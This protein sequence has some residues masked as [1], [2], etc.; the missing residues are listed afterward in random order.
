M[1]PKSSPL[2]LSFYWNFASRPKRKSS[3]KK[4][5]CYITNF[6]QRLKK[7]SLKS[8]SV[9]VFQRALFKDPKKRS[10]KTLTLTD[11]K[12][13]FF[14]S[15]KSAPKSALWKLLHLQ[16]SKSA[17]QRPKKALFEICKCKSFSK[18]AFLGL[19]KRSLK[20]L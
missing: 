9:R 7:R 20:T 17:F 5:S 10:L 4:L 8:V 19:W 2:Q 16:I 15:L 18:S 1:G 14:G 12:E 11:F 3:P 13:R 6:F